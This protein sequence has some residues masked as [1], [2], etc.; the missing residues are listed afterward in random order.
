MN[1]KEQYCAFRAIVDKEV[2]RI[3]RIWMQTLLPSAITMTL[4]FIIFGKFIGSQVRDINGFSYMQF[5]VPGII[6]LSVITNSF[7][8]VVSAFFSAKFQKSIEELLVSPTPNYIIILGYAAGGVFRGLL[9]GIIVLLVSL[10]FFTQLHI[11]NL[12]IVI[13][14]ILLT[15]IVFSLGGLL[16]AIFAKRFDDI[17]IVP[18]FVLMPLTYLGGVFYSI[19]LLPEFWQAVSLFN[20]ILYMVNGFRYGFLGISDINIWIGLGML[21]IFAVIL[22]Y[23]NLYLIKKGVGL[24]A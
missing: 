5:I 17:A 15:S 3:L 8:N 21:I 10:L 13:A 22:F 23:A 24:R 14:F 9:V 16:N 20:P 4:Y 19:K 11:Y 2:T 1:A 6:M 12:A 18:T 7:T